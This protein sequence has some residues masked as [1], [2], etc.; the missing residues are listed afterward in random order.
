MKDLFSEVDSQLKVPRV[1][2]YRPVYSLDVYLCG[3]IPQCRSSDSLKDVMTP[4]I[5]PVPDC[6]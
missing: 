2:L 6:T 5:V 4:L 3:L 1:G